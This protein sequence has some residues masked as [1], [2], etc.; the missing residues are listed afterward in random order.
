VGPRRPATVLVLWRPATSTPALL[1]LLHRG[2][3]CARPPSPPPGRL[4][5]PRAQLLVGAPLASRA[6][7]PDRPLPA[8]WRAGAVAAAAAAPAP[9]ST[10][11]Y[12]K[13]RTKQYCKFK[14]IFNNNQKIILRYLR[15]MLL[16][17]KQYKQC[18]QN[19]INIGF[20]NV[21]NQYNKLINTMTTRIKTIIY[22]NTTI[23]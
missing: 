5:E 17:L 21:C 12:S 8:C 11:L 19:T 22:K 16:T 9:W 20:N 10:I 2:S 7:M 6:G 23:Q 15:T 13:T 14:T 18:L 3:R 1:H 4:G